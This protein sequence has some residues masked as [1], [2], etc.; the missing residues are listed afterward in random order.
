ME[1]KIKDEQH[2]QFFLSLILTLVH[3]AKSCFLY[4]LYYTFSH[5]KFPGKQNRL[6]MLD[7]G[8]GC[9]FR[10]AKCPR[11]SHRLCA[12]V[13]PSRLHPMHTLS[14]AL[15]VPQSRPPTAK[16]LER[17]SLL[18]FLGVWPLALSLLLGNLHGLLLLQ[19]SLVPPVFQGL[20]TPLQIFTGIYGAFTVKWE[21]RDLQGSTWYKITSNCYCC[22]T[23]NT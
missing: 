15:H 22:F 2:V 13:S 19:F 12:G 21:Y 5:G 20:S 18:G 23:K 8:P 1:K 10:L 4:M 6:S 11:P 7:W 9:G 14:L 17:V 3:N 16:P